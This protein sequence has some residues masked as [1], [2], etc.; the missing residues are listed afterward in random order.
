MLDS[1]EYH[2]AAAG[3]ARMA[4]MIIHPETTNIRANREPCIFPLMEFLL[5]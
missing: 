5:R 1:V 3:D 4:D 2:L